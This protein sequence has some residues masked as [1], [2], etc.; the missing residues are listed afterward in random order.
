M[1][2]KMNTIKFKQITKKKTKIIKLI[3][4][5]IYYDNVILCGTLII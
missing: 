1:P 5:I 3:K 2:Q 4:I